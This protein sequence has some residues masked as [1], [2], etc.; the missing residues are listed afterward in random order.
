MLQ[1][2]CSWGYGLLEN[3]IF[4]YKILRKLSWKI[5]SVFMV[6]FF[7]WKILCVLLKCWTRSP[8]KFD[9]LLW[10]FL[11]LE[12]PMC[13][14]R[15]SRKLFWK[16]WCVLVKTFCLSRKIYMC[17]CTIFGSPEKFDICSYKRFMSS[18]GKFILVIV[19]LLHP[20]LLE[21]LMCFRN[22]FKKVTPWK[23][24]KKRAD[25]LAN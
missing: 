25:I 21:N 4:S 20:S 5:W 11:F 23:N 6:F 12:N 10:Y 18:P 17:S 22:L 1:N 14:C 19:F 9:L 8:G 15:I 2:I 7:S 13:S 16:F 24:G 3:R